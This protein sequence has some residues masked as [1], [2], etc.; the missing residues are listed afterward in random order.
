MARPHIYK[1][2]HSTATFGGKERSILAVPRMY[3]IKTND[4]EYVCGLTTDITTNVKHYERMFY[5]SRVSAE[6]VA[7]NLNQ[8]YRSENYRVVEI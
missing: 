3:A 8:T 6:R 1:V 4:G 5:A 7:Q 2:L